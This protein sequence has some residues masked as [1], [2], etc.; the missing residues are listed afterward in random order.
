MS[1]K[2]PWPCKS[3]SAVSDTLA[4]WGPF[5]L[6][7]K[8]GRGNDERSYVPSSGHTCLYYATKRCVL[9]VETLCFESYDRSWAT[10]VAQRGVGHAGVLET[11]SEQ[12]RCHPRPR[13]SPTQCCSVPTPETT[14]GQIDGFFSQ[15]P[16]KCHLPE[17]ASVGD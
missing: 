14:S 15:L 8:R 2:Q 3:S 16:Y 17:V 1:S 10:Q 9:K 11:F 7:V 12:A 5:I 4:Y 6:L 13:L